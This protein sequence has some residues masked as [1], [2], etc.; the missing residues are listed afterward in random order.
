VVSGKTEP[1]SVIAGT[2]SMVGL[3]GIIVS[4]GGLGEKPNEVEGSTSAST[5]STT[6]FDGLV[7]T[8]V[9]RGGMGM[10]DLLLL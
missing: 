3:G 1:V 7:F 10:C 5:S 9:L 4:L 2:S 6:G 8:G